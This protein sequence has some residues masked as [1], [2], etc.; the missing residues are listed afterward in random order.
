M[1]YLA[2]IIFENNS[3]QFTVT[4]KLSEAQKFIY[5]RCDGSN[6]FQARIFDLNVNESDET[7]IE[8]YTKE[9]FAQ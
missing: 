9:N 5:D 1:N 2:H 3:E 4:E 7:N 8:I 6:L